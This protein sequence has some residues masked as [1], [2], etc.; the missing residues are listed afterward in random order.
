M[1]RWRGGAHDPDGGADGERDVSVEFDGGAGADAALTGFLVDEQFQV[2]QACVPVEVLAGDG[3]AQGECA[4]MGV[5]ASVGDL[6]T[7][8]A[9]H[10]SYPV[11]EVLLEQGVLVGAGQDGAGEPGGDGGLLVVEEV[12]VPHP[13]G[14]DELERGEAGGAAHDAGKVVTLLDCVVATRHGRLP[15][16]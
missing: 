1:V 3:A 5:G 13:T 6:E 7:A 9:V 15:R 14:R 4:L 16:W 11:D 10:T 2:E 8:D 12:F